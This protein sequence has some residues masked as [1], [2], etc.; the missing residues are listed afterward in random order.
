MP[1]WFPEVRMNDNGTFQMVLENKLLS[2]VKIETV[3][4]VG[5]CQGRTIRGFLRTYHPRRIHG[6]EPNQVNFKKA[7][8]NLDGIP[9]VSLHNVAVSD[10][11]GEGV[12]RL[13]ATDSGHSLLHHSLR[14]E[15]ESEQK[16]TLI[17]LDNW[18][19]ENGVS[20]FDYLKIDTQGNDF[21]VIKGMGNKIQ[22]VKILKAEVWFCDDGYEGGHLFHEVMGYLYSQGFYLYNFTN[23]TYYKNARLRWGDAVFLREDILNEMKGYN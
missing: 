2:R 21:R 10:V 18:M 3:A 13:A 6:F 16:T 4:D 9:E 20:G 19:E 15:P 14:K 5:C 1:E 11:S 23:L 12:L 17:R 7:K 8:E 22:T